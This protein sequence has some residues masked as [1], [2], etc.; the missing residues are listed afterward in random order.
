VLAEAAIAVTAAPVIIPAPNA[1]AELHDDDVVPK[2][3]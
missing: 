2:Q 3:P 1:A